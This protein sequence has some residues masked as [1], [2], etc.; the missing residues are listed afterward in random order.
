MPEE[1][2]FVFYSRS[3]FRLA[4]VQEG[5]RYVDEQGWGKFSLSVHDDLPGFIANASSPEC[6][7]VGVDTSACTQPRN[8]LEVGG[9]VRRVAPTKPIL[10]VAGTGELSPRDWM[11]AGEMGVAELILDEEDSNAV[12]I[13]RR[14]RS[15]SGVSLALGVIRSLEGQVPTQWVRMLE[16]GLVH[17]RRATADDAGLSTELLADLWNRGSSRAQLQWYLQKDGD[18]TPGWLVRWLI[19]L[20]ALSLRSVRP[21][22]ARVASDLGFSRKEDLRAYVRR[23]TGVR[24]DELTAERLKDAFLR[25][26]HGPRVVDGERERMIPSESRGFHGN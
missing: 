24:E 5:L 12:A 23:F 26:S 21:S 10:L 6:E 16:R 25:R 15:V 3:R 19:C 20:K 1:S 7:V 17:A 14:I 4:R 13:A 11:R 2:T 18:W 9:E 8:A 22:W